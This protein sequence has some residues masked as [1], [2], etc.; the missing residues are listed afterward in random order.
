MDDT[1]FVNYTE[2][3]GIHNWTVWN[4]VTNDFGQ[5]FFSL[6]IVSPAHALLAIVSAYFIG[7]R[8][9]PFYL[10]TRQQKWVLYTRGVA[11]LGLAMTP[12]ICLIVTAALHA[13]VL[14]EEG[15]SYYIDASVEIFSWL[16]HFI[17]VIILLERVTPSIRG[18]RKAL[19][20]FIMVAIVD[21]LRCKTLITREEIDPTIYDVTKFLG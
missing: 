5:C 16:L 20:V 3:C 12:V 1:T 19:C 14:V 17:Y 2:L 21:C 11:T 18:R 7:L 9:T 13:D 10:R 4:N 8:S 6:A 15:I